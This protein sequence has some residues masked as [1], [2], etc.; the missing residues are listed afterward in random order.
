M[1]LTEAQDLLDEEVEGRSTVLGGVVEQTELL[2]KRLQA[3]LADLA[4][5]CTPSCGGLGVLD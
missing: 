3:R 2:E 5:G 4:V 1:Q